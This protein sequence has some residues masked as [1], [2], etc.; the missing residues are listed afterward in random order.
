MKVRKNMIAVMLLVCIG[1]SGCA[2]G[3][4]KADAGNEIRSEDVRNAGNETKSGDTGSTAGKQDFPE[5]F[6]ET[7]NGVVFDTVIQVSEE[8]ELGNLHQVTATLQRPDVEK[9]KAVFAEGKTATEERNETE[10]GEDG[11]EY[12]GYTGHYEDGAFLSASTVLVYSTPVFEKIYGAFRLDHDYNADKYSKDAVME[13]GDPRTIF[14]AALKDINGAGYQLEEAAYDYYALDHETMAKEYRALDKSG[15]EISADG[16]SWGAE[17]DCYFFAAVQQDEGLPVY[18][19]SQDFP[20]DSESNRPVQVLYSAGGIERLEVSRLYSFS[21][22][23]DAVSLL[24]FGTVAETV[25]KKYGDVIG[26]SYT[27]KRAK[28]YKMPV[29]LADGTYDVKIAWLFEVT[30]SGTDSDT[31]KEYEY[32]QYMFVDAADGTEVLF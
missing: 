32:T 12:P 23:G 15:N 2:K 24:D 20:E 9:A 19:G 3:Q 1:C 11:R 17:N 10:S 16:L 18:F 14:D 26:A 8:A 13:I 30:E 21:E 7:I 27:V 25:S 29:K 31:G 22:P 4:P 6:Q 28:L 5:T